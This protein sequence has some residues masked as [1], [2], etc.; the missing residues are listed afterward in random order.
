MEVQV[1]ASINRSSDR[2]WVPKNLIDHSDTF[3]DIGDI[4]RGHGSKPRT[5]IEEGVP[6]FADGYEAYLNR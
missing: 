3:A 5:N 4:A 2:P 1:G 6:R